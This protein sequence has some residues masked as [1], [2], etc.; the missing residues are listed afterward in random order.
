MLN[1]DVKIDD[2]KNES[3][4][5]INNNILFFRKNTIIYLSSV[6][7]GFIAP[8]GSCSLFSERFW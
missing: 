6:R 3:D 1:L 8:L 5:V 2:D 7:T 4:K